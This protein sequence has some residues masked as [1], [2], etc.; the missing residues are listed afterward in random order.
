MPNFP[1]YRRILG[2]VRELS[3]HWLEAIARGAPGLPWRRLR[4]LVLRSRS[5]SRGRGV[6]FT[7]HA[8]GSVV[9]CPINRARVPAA[10]ACVGGIATDLSLGVRAAGRA[11]ARQHHRACDIDCTPP[12]PSSRARELT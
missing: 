10:K 4:D 6:R 12:R 3:A 2:G 11:A 9:Y 8:A 7:L 5:R 1:S